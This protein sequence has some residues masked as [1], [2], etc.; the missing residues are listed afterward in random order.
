MSDSHHFFPGGQKQDIILKAL[1]GLPGVSTQSSGVGLWNEFIIL[2][3]EIA[4]PLSYVVSST[5]VGFTRYGLD[6]IG[7][8]QSQLQS[9]LGEAANQWYMQGAR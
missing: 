3:E 2:L 5:A 9:F 1:G 4:A 8:V 7:R 6:P